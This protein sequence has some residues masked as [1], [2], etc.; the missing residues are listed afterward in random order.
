MPQE[1]ERKFLVKNDSWRAAAG[2]GVELRQ[3]FVFSR[4]SRC[5]VRI[6]T[7]MTTAF[8]TMKGQRENISRAEYEYEIPLVD[9]EEMLLLCDSHAVEKVRYP[10]IHA[11][12]MW[13]VDVFSGNNTGLVLAEIEL[14]SEDEIFDF[15]A[16][17]GEEVSSD[18]RYC[19]SRLA[20][21]P[22]R[23]WNSSV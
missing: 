7:A 2:D 16:W 23:E 19:N 18:D 8:I 4:E 9:A 21:H 14:S 6:R 11:G 1:I 13:V 5:V 12:Y 15:P 10:V 3:A 20:L 22:Y 17:V